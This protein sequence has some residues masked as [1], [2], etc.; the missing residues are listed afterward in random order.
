MTTR[1]LGQVY[2]PSYTDK[3]TGALKTSATWWLVYHVRGVR[4]RESA[5]STH[6]PDAVRLLKKRLGDIGTGRPVGPA[7]E[8]TTFEHLAEML[9]NDYRANTRRS[10]PR[11]LSAV[12]HLRSAFGLARALDLT[13]D[14]ISS[15]VADRLAAEAK[16]A[17]VNRELAA[18]KRMF[19]LGQ[20][21][22]KVGERP[23]IALLQEKNTRKG[24]FESEQWAAVAP[25]L[26]ADLRPVFEVAY[27]TGWR[28]KS[29]LLTRQRHHVDLAAG[30]LRLEPGE[31][32]NTEG[33]MFPL[34]P[35]LRAVLAAQLD[36]TRAVETATG[37]VVPW[38]FH[39]DGKPI[40][41]FAARGRPPVGSPA[42]RVG[43][44][45]T[46]AGRRCGTSSARACR[47]QRRWRWSGIR[48]RRSIAGTRL[49]TRA[50]CATA[51]P[52]RST[53]RP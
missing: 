21:A 13:A 48:P 39:R 40:K 2:Q 22:G 50:C 6:R 29:E 41:S 11:A 16:P 31:T 49:P 23:Y 12:S 8:R 28:V 15:Y 53:P 47:A 43:S 34:T 7:L 19:R 4:Y 1:G 38:L 26:S 45:T 35:R 36:H 44:P 5:H 3:K 9:L 24:F 30:W 20:R 37:R 46:F 52:A 32:K 14:R 27:I 33:R 18:L 42:C 10:L 51:A 25:H 17:T